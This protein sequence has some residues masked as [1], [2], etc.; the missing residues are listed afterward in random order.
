MD[1]ILGIEDQIEILCFFKLDRL[2]REIPLQD[3]QLLFSPSLIAS[4][5]QMLV[6]GCNVDTS[7]QAGCKIVNK[8]MLT[9]GRITLKQLGI[10]IELVG[11]FCKF[12]RIVID[13]PSGSFFELFQAEWVYVGGKVPST[14]LENCFIF[15]I[16]GMGMGV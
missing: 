2:F 14:I 5:Q 12:F 6:I 3:R 1:L 16:R 8:N 9:K 4:L 10:L 7:Q 13:E 15:G 11:N